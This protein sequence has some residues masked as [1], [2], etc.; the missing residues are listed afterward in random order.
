M[1]RDLE[2]GTREA[3]TTGSQSA[4]PCPGPGRAASTDSCFGAARPGR[5]RL[6]RTHQTDHNAAGAQGTC[7]PPHPAESGIG[8]LAERGPGENHA[9][10]AL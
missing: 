3:T 7:S 1:S 8:T 9:G 2:I 5:K 4:D 10:P 6:A